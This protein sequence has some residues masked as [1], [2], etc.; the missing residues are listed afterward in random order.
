[1][2]GSYCKL[3]KAA[4]SYGVDKNSKPDNKQQVK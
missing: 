1:M 3:T 4:K 2:E